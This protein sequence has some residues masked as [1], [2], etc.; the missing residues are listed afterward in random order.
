MNKFTARGR[1]TSGRGVMLIELTDTETKKTTFEYMWL[2]DQ[3]S[4]KFGERFVSK[5]DI[6]SP[7]G[8]ITKTE[9]KFGEKWENSKIE[10]LS[11]DVLAKA[12]ELA[13]KIQQNTYYGYSEDNHTARADSISE[14][15]ERVS[16]R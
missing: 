6:K 13:L 2:P 4:G 10:T 1:R 7:N 15:I 5:G 14:K 16:R 11:G 8:V 3:K 12:I 9:W